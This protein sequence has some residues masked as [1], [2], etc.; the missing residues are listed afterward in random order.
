MASR[1]ISPFPTLLQELTRAD[2]NPG[3]KRAAA[4][5]RFKKVSVAHFP[6]VNAITDNDTRL[7]R[8]TRFCLTR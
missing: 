7:A 6:N 3:D 1:Y 8:R 2:K 5:E 4:E